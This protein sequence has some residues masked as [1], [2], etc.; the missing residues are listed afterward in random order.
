MEWDALFQRSVEHQFLPLVLRRDLPS[1]D[2]FP[3]SPTQ[4]EPANPPG[5]PDNEPSSAPAPTIPLKAFTPTGNIEYDVWRR[6]FAQRAQAAGRNPDIVWSVLE[7]L[8]PMPEASVATSFNDNQAEFVKPIWNYVKSATSAV[9][10]NNGKTKLDENSDMF[11]RIEADYGVPREI[12]TAIWGMETAYGAVLGSY[13]SPRMLATL[14]Y[15]GRRTEL[16]EQQL[17]AVFKLLEQEEVTRDQLRTASWAGAVGQTQFMP[18]TFVGYAR[19]GD[20][21]NRKDLW[22]S[23]ADALA[24]AANYLTESGWRRGEP[25]ALEVILPGNVDYMLADGDKRSWAFWTSQGYRIADGRQIDPNLRAEL[26]LPAG[27]YGPA[28]LLFDNFY[29]LRVYNN[30]DSYALSIGLLADQLVNRPAL[31]RDWPTN[32]QLPTREQ[33]RQMQAGLNVLGYNAGPVD[34]LAGRLTR[35]ALR[36]YQFDRGLTP[37]GFA[38]RSVVNRVIGET[39]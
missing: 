6:D 36:D 30:A 27:S 24:S 31:T 13:D 28:F 15:K 14:A 32:I 18:G 25:W 8:S 5:A 33:V 26:F 10:V 3:N 17:I 2:T 16:G 35:S 39:G 4:P 19:D 7:G 11:G 22:G 20:G 38:T 12:L 1:R 34:G 29:K 23:S 9:R 21:D 37:D